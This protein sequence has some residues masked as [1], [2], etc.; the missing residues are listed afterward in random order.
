MYSVSY[1]GITV[2]NYQN[3]VIDGGNVSVTFT[4]DIP[5][6]V[7]PYAGGVKL[8]NY[9][10]ANNQITVENVTSDITLKYLEKV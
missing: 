1:E 5:K 6:K 2:H 3:K 7:I 10:Y 9:T 8:S 4:E